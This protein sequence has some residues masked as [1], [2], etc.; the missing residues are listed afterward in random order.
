[1]RSHEDKNVLNR[2]P[3]HTWRD[4]RSGETGLALPPGEGKHLP[5][6]SWVL[7]CFCEL[8]TSVRSYKWTSLRGTKH[9]FPS[10]SCRF[11]GLPPPK[12]VRLTPS[13][14]QPSGLQ[15]SHLPSARATMTEHPVTSLASCCQGLLEEEGDCPLFPHTCLPKPI[16]R[17][18]PQ[19]P[20]TLASWSPWKRWPQRP[21]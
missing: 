15:H 9:S 3:L 17:G 2:V 6:G 13:L 7:C 1:M 8:P 18:H 21:S 19:F 11:P 10:C 4:A 20:C 14:T 5:R 16:H 12:G